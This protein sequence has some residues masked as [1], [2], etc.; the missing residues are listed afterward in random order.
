MYLSFQ[1]H[2]H[3]R[4]K[5]L[6][7]FRLV[8]YHAALSTEKKKQRKTMDTHFEMITKYSHL[9]KLVALIGYKGRLGGKL[10][11]SSDAVYFLTPWSYFILKTENIYRSHQ[12]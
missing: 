1:L 7:I 11:I 12:K 4:I 10:E 2:F 8:L 5:K 3:F 9:I 6:E